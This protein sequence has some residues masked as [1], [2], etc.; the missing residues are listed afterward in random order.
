MHQ[1][2]LAPVA[3][4]N[5]DDDNDMLDAVSNTMQQLH[6]ASGYSSPTSATAQDQATRGSGEN[7]FPRPTAHRHA[8]TSNQGIKMSQDI[9]IRFTVLF[10]K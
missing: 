1:D 10:T 3:V 6:T 7:R 2:P 5:I 4:T 8:A 9:I